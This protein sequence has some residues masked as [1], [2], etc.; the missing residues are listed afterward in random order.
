[1]KF[2]FFMSRFRWR[3]FEV[4]NWRCCWVGLKLSFR[5]FFC[6]VVAS[7]LRNIMNELQIKSSFKKFAWVCKINKNKFSCK[8]LLEE[9]KKTKK[10]TKN[11]SSEYQDGWN[12]HE[13]YLISFFF[14]NNQAIPRWTWNTS[15]RLHR[16]RHEDINQTQDNHLIWDFIWENIFMFGD[17]SNKALKNTKGW[18]CVKKTA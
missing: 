11:L 5:S 2:E 13:L 8:L 9:R 1:M 7:F 4:K 10:E 6:R 16:C 14:R 3:R 12:L 15:F 17:P 18:R